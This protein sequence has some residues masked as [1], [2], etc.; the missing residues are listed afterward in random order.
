MVGR[1][2]RCRFDYLSGNRVDA[3]RAKEGG[4]SCLKRGGQRFC[5][6]C[7]KHKPRGKRAAVKGWKCDDCLSVIR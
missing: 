1:G 7:H 6:T 2:A 5:E 3:E 4:V